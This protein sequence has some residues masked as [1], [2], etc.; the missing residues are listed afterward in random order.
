MPHQRP[1][2]GPKLADEEN[3]IDDRLCDSASMGVGRP[4][5]KSQAEDE[6]VRDG[7]RPC[8]V[9]VQQGRRINMSAAAVAEATCSWIG[10]LLCGDCGSGR[11]AN[12]R[13][14]P[15]CHG[16]PGNKMNVVLR[17][18]DGSD[19]AVSHASRWI[20]RL[21]SGNEEVSRLRRYGRGL[22]WTS[23]QRPTV[24]DPHR[25]RTV[26]KRG[27][28]QELLTDNDTVFRGRNFTEFVARWG[29]R[30]R[31]P[32]AY[33][34]SGN[35]IAERCHRSVKVIAARKN[36]TVEEAVYLYNVT[37]RDGRN[38]W[39]APANVV[40]AYAVRVRGVDQATEEPE[41]MNG[42]FAVGD[43]VWVRP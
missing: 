36:C 39:T 13:R 35:G 9:S 30:V 33:A 18:A 27:A 42:R 5:R 16:S 32:C 31:Y 15:S 25:L 28:Q 24:P 21:E 29:V 19:T 37:P 41:E 1:Q 3:S 26:A 20:R 43:S 14:C 11:G 34:P 7:S 10:A 17:K 4:L 23:P 38:P 2:F 40:H 22:E 12:D 8:E 6:S